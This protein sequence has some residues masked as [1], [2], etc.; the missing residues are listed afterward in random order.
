MRSQP[1][2]FAASMKSIMAALVAVA[3]L[4]AASATQA[5]DPKAAE[6]LARKSAC[7]A[8]HTID[9]KLV[10][11]SYRDV[12]AKYRGQQDA[13]AGLIEKVK[14]GGQG[15]WGQMPMPPNAQVKDEDVKTLVQ[16]VL[17]TE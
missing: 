5:V 11:P 7:M 6:E 17:S 16:W 12:A 8:C 9:K 13:E 10:G 1:P 3:G 14:K 4:A 2:F 15:V